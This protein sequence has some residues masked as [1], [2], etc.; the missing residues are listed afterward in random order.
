VYQP[1]ARQHHRVGRLVHLE[2]AEL[3]LHEGDDLPM[4]EVRENRSR[5]KPSVC[6]ALQHE[7]GRLQPILGG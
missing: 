6:Q 1:R 2:H 5:A 3:P 4:V 7:Q